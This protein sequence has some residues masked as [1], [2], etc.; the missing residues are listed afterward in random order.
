M[1]D[2]DIHSDH[3]RHWDGME[4]SSVC[5]VCVRGVYVTF[6][7]TVLRNEWQTKNVYGKQLMDV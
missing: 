6:R 7:F 1:D 5:D 4:F 2:F 3:H